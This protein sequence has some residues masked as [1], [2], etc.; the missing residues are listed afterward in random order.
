MFNDQNNYFL[1]LEKLTET[2][3]KKTI[4]ILR[5][6]AEV[7]ENLIINFHLFDF[8]S[9]AQLNFPQNTTPHPIE[10]FVDKK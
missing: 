7:E 1:D 9:M 6:I 2:R 5:L 4:S 3:G 8:H 10:L